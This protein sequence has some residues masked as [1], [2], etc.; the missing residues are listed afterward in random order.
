MCKACDTARANPISGEYL[1]GCDGCAARALAVSPQFHEP[2]RL[3]I[4]T[5]NY[6]RALEQFFP[7]RAE[8][9]H[10]AAKEWLRIVGP[11]Q[12]DRAG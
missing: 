8:A 10:A 12:P 6:A 11:K 7:G 2:L 4:R 1:A 3:G 5:G 9:G